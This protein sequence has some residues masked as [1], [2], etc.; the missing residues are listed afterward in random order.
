V[1]LDEEVE[2]EDDLDEEV[3]DDQ[4]D[5]LEEVEVDLEKEKA[6]EEEI[7]L[8]IEKLM[9]INLANI[10][11]LDI[12]LKEM[13]KDDKELQQEE[14]VEVVVVLDEDNYF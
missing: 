3:E 6:F 14:I 5:D 12:L 8:L 2:E 1:V 11:V 4:E 10:E 9:T 13:N 7:V